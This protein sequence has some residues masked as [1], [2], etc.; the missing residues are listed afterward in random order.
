MNGLRSSTIDLGTPVHFVDFGG[1][2][3]PM[4]LVHGLGG[5]AENWFAVGSALARRGHVVALDLMGFGRT[6]PGQDGVELDAN[7]RLLDRFLTAVAGGPAI[8]VGNSMGGLIAMMEAARSPDRVAGLVLVSPA[9]PRLRGAPIDWPLLLALILYS[10]P[11]L[12]RKLWRRRVRRLG[13]AGLV[14]DLFRIVCVDPSRV[15]RDVRDAHVALVAERLARMPWA[16][17]AFVTAARSLMRA[18]ARKQEWQAMV[19]A[20]K[21]PTLVVQGARDRLVPLMASRT[22]VQQRP[23]WRLEVLEDIGHVAQLEAAG[24]FSALVERW[25]DGAGRPAMSRATRRS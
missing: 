14:D 21:A 11:W 3:P 22:L 6:P 13:P 19:S 20:I 4:V 18:L 16:E 1:A 25:L 7:Y 24:R 10:I 9:Q 5:A 2:G 17:D 12:G 23:D 15:P 8:V